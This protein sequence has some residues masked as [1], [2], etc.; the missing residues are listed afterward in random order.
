MFDRIHPCPCGYFSDSLKPCRCAQAPVTKHQKRIS[1]PMLDR[2]D[3][4]IEAL[5]VDYKKLSG[6][7]VGE[8]SDAILVRVQA[9]RNIQPAGFS[10][11]ESSNV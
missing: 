5:C 1:G 6:D 8:S 9:A 10:K 3:I 11:I 2:I 7:R 4:L